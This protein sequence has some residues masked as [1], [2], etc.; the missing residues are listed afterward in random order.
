LKPRP[1][2]ATSSIPN[3]IVSRELSGLNAY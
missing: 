2:A 1:F 3:C